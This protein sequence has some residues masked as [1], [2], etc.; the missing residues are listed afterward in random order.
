[1]FIGIETILKDHGLNQGGG[2]R[3]AGFVETR[4]LPGVTG[5]DVP[6]PT[7]HYNP[8]R[9]VGLVFVNGT[10]VAPSHY[11]IHKQETLRFNEALTGQ[12]V[13]FVI[14]KTVK[15]QKPLIDGSWVEDQSIFYNK[16]SASLKAK[17]ADPAVRQ[18]AEQLVADTADELDEMQRT[19]A[20]IELFWATQDRIQGGT[21]FGDDFKTPPLGATFLDANTKLATAANSGQTTVLVTDASRLRVGNEVTLYDNISFERR[22][23]TNIVNNSVTLDTALTQNMKTGAVVTRSMGVRDMAAKQYRLPVWTD[24]VDSRTYELA[25]FDVRYLLPENDRFVAWV[26]TRDAYVDVKASYPTQFQLKTRLVTDGAPDIVWQLVTDTSF[27]FETRNGFDRT[28]VKYNGEVVADYGGGNGTYT[29]TLD[30]SRLKAGEN[31]VLVELTASERRAYAVLVV[32]KVPVETYA[33]TTKT[34]KGDETQATLH[35]EG[36]GASVIRITFTR[37][38][39]AIRP[40]FKRLLGGIDRE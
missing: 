40:T 20:A 34:V 11:Q 29:H 35:R 24:P 21:L 25:T 13:S 7:S 15:P 31:Q 33:S 8:T 6:L 38:D 32:E 10:Y 36:V 37:K 16:L 30:A 23:I 19:F 3:Y 1:M 27:R 9:D 14:L 17:L 22:R 5:T 18:A 28:V 39:Q 12:S 2:S 4:A 26:E